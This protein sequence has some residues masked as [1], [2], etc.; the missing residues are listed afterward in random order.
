MDIQ[1]KNKFLT[2]V[3]KTLQTYVFVV[4]IQLKTMKHFGVA[5]AVLWCYVIS[6]LLFKLLLFITNLFWMQKLK[7]KDFF[8][9]RKVIQSR[10]S[11]QQVH[12][13]APYKIEW[14]I[15]FLIMLKLYVGLGFICITFVLPPSSFCFCLKRHPVKQKS[16]FFKNLITFFSIVF[17]SIFFHL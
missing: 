17:S 12:K 6:V 11:R 8:W 15:Y 14:F 16:L 4:S 7:G 9:I 5:N 13:R 2:E 1:F 10:Q 3:D